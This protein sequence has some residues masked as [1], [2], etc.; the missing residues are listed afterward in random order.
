MQDAP[1]PLPALDEYVDLRA[2]LPAVVHT[3]PTQD[4]VK[5]FVRQH[6]GELAENGAL[7]NITGRLRFHPG[8][9]AQ[10]AV[11]IGNRAAAPLKVRRLGR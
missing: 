3:F 5:W 4:S 1:Q 10:A 6:R 11:E 8:R 7:I 2:L 9:F